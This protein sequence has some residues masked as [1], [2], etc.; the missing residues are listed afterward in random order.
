MTEAMITLSLSERRTFS[1]KPTPALSVQGGLV[2]TMHGSPLS[3]KAAEELVK[4]HALAVGFTKITHIR[5]DEA[6]QLV[7]GDANLYHVKE[8]LGHESLNMFKHYAKLNTA[9]LQRTLKQCHP[10]EKKK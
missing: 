8:L 9:D 7:R 6:R 1:P 5:S 3:V 10:R 2:L 4:K